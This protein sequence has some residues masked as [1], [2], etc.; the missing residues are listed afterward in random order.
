MSRSRMAYSSWP[1]AERGPWLVT[2]TRRGRTVVFSRHRTR[3]AAEAE[4]GRL[5]DMNLPAGV[6]RE[7]RLLQAG[8]AAAVTR[9][10]PGGAR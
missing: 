7:R 2:L 9:R 3:Q 4:C 10:T 5:L 6:T 1:S 8:H